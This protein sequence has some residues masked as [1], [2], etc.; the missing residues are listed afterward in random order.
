VRTRRLGDFEVSAIGLGT[1]EIDHDPTGALRALTA[2]IEAGL[3]HIDT[4][5]AYG[6]GEVE[7]IVARAIAG[8]ARERVFVA[9]KVLPEHATFEG[10]ISACEGSL[11]RLGTDRLDLYLLHEPSEHPLEETIHAFDRLLEAGKIRSFGV[12]NFDV[13]ELEHAVAI[14]GPGRIVCNQVIHHLR[15]RYVEGALARCCEAH[16]VALVGYAPFGGGDFPESGEA[17]RDM[18]DAVAE[19]HAATARQVCLAFLLRDGRSLSIPRTTDQ[20]HAQEN[21]AAIEIELTPDE[22]AALELSFPREP[23]DRLPRL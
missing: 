5:E 8:R 21:A 17:E 15:E 19:C 4:A 23:R 22:V 11:R 20:R 7:R 10:T 14:A 3:T 13:E 6:D 9:S 16:E 2:G 1:A 12:S 18:L